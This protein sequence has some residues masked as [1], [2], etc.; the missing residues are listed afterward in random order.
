MEAKESMNI[1]NLLKSIYTARAIYSV[2]NPPCCT[3]N[4]PPADK[5][6]PKVRNLLKIHL[7][8]KV[9]VK[10]S[11]PCSTEEFFK[12]NITDKVSF[13]CQTLEQSRGG[14]YNV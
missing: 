14:L 2:V 13:L 3:I 4:T 5:K 12:N 1:I 6:Q 7:T 8:D 11:P 10:C 9:F